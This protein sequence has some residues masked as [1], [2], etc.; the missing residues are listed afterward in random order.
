MR[1]TEL[2]YKLA[3][4]RNAGLEAR[5]TRTSNRAPIIAAK[6][7]ES[8]TWCVVDSRMWKEMQRSGDVLETFKDFTALVDVF[9]IRA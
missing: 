6:R 5:W 1:N 7:W 2:Q 8:S 3:T 4:F 9:S